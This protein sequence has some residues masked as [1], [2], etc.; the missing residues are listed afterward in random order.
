MTHQQAVDGLASE[1]Y[2]L[3]EMSEV[4][5]FEFESHYFD[6]VEC[7]DDVRVGQLMRDEV[8]RGGASGATDVVSGADVVSLADVAS[9][10]PGRRSA[11]REG[12][13]RTKGKVIPFWRRPSVALPWAAAAALALTVSYQSFVTVPSLRDSV[14]SESLAPIVLR[15]ATRGTVPV[16]TIAPRQR[17]VTLAI[18]IVS[19][20]AP[21]LRY[22]LS[23]AGGAPALSGDAP[24]PPAG[25]P[26]LLLLPAAELDRGARYSLIIRSADSANAVIGEYDFDVS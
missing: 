26:L 20:Q 25:A 12:G 22:E 23:R 8:K 19:S 14:A 21:A 24:L 11:E 1:R 6:C 17:Y 3:D 2:L 5:R 10:F 18:D 13:S 4:E 7:A 16:V 9:G 15:G